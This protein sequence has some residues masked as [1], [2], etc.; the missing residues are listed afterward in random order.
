MFVDGPPKRPVLV[1]DGPPKRPVLAVVV[2]TVV[3]VSGATVIVPPK[4]VPWPVP[5]TVLG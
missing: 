3:D 2:L 1:V 5:R 4:P